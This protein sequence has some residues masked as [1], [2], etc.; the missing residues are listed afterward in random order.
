M[1]MHTHNV[2][3]QHICSLQKEVTAIEKLMDDKTVLIQHLEMRVINAACDNPG[4]TVTTRLLLP[5][6]QVWISR[7]CFFRVDHDSFGHIIN[8]A[9]DNPGPTLGTHLLTFEFEK[10]LLLGVCCEPARTDTD[11]QHS[12]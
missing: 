8:T 7:V 10:L 6:L 3:T 2:S 12:P 4:P 5:V 9:C 11:P 1:H